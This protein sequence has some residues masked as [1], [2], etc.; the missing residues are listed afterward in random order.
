MLD[1]I[2]T[3]SIIKK[4]IERHPVA[5]YKILYD[6]YKG[7]HATILNRNTG[8]SSKP[9]NRIINNFPGYIVDVNLGYFMGV[10]VRYTSKANNTELIDILTPIFVF[11]D[12]HDENTELAKT[13]GI[14]G[15]AFEIIYFDEDGKLRFD[16]VE[17]KNLI[18]VYDSSIEPKPLYAI[19]FYEE[20]YP[21][22]PDETTFCVN[23]YTP[24]S[25]IQYSGTDLE[26]LEFISE[27]FHPFGGV[28]IVE[29]LNNDERQSDFEK[30]LELIDAYDKSQ[31]DTANDFEY[32]S[33]AYLK[34]KGMMGTDL[35]TV[36]SMRENRVLL[37]SG[38]GDA[39]WLIKHIND[40]AEEN[41][42]KRL[43]DD[44]HKFS[45]TAN[46]TDEA[47]AGNL[48]GVALKY[49]LWGMEQNTAQKERKFKRGLQRRIE[50]ITNYLS[51]KG[52]KYDWRD[53]G[54]VFSRNIPEN[55][56]DIT[57]MTKGLKG[58]VSEETLLSQIPF[59]EDPQL[60]LERI[61]KEQKRKL[62]EK[63]DLMQYVNDL[64]G[65][66]QK[67]DDVVLYGEDDD[68]RRED[69]YKVKRER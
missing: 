3:P 1:I 25:I 13:M 6:Y 66:G 51:I 29:Y 35:D 44:I 42:K 23:V 46:L 26:K 16:V 41:Y 62:I 52:K 20:E 32:F 45:K 12:E 59:V 11:N 48:S 68:E 63:I 39:D 58:T 17:P 67:D 55:I 22:D 49:K 43:V 56:L 21:N 53:I 37:L 10:P 8:G 36:D 30:V 19:H 40:E 18:M 28:P 54:I 65:V 34:I 5:R 31:S 27:V 7:D 2:I 57:E 50:L 60:E 47:F 69:D 15:H 24:T 4:R 9:D 38:D 61:E 14:K 64:G 33:D